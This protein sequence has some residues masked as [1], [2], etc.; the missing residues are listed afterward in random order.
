[1]DYVITNPPISKKS[2]ITVTN[3]EGEQEDEDLTYNRILG[4]NILQEMSKLLKNVKEYL[5]S[6]YG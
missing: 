5:L 2:S 1:V 3:E 4:Y 6:C